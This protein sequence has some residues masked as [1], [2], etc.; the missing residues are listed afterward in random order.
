MTPPA[1]VLPAV[2][3]HRWRKSGGFPG[4]SVPG[5]PNAGATNAPRRRFFA[6]DREGPRCTSLR[7]MTTRVVSGE[8]GKLALLSIAQV[9]VGQSLAHPK[10]SL[11]RERIW[12]TRSPPVGQDQSGTRRKEAR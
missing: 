11:P 9:L 5:E 6:A 2:T 4:G 10:S 1:F 3:R 7:T 12:Q 8:V